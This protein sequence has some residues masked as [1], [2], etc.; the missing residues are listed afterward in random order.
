MS[1]CAIQYTPMTIAT[2]DEAK[3]RFRG[4]FSLLKALPKRKEPSPKAPAVMLIAAI[5][6]GD[7]GIGGMKWCGSG[8]G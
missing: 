4:R 6:P 8:S 2:I 3:D 5:V 7:G 1:A